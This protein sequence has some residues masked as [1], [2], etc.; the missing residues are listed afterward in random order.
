MTAGNTYTAGT[1]GGEATHTLTVDEMPSHQHTI[2]VHTGGNPDGWSDYGRSYW[3][4]V[5]GTS[6]PSTSL[7]GGGQAHNNMPPY[8]VVY[9]WRRVS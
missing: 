2:T 1:T 3:S 6:D 4:N 8:L 9:A 5:W 7:V